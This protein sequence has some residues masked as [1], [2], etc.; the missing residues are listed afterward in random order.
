MKSRDDFKTD[1]EYREYLRKY[2][3]AMAM[4]GLSSIRVGYGA[5]QDKVIDGDVQIAVKYADALLSELEKTET[6]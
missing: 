5:N 6:P 3:A 2:F 4:Q 1:G